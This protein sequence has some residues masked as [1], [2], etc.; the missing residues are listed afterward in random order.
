MSE[1]ETSFISLAIAAVRLGLPKSWLLNE[2]IADRVPHI[3]IGRRFLFNLVA[4]ERSL[5][6]RAATNNS[7]QKSG[8]DDE[9]GPSSVNQINHE[10]DTRH[11]Q[12][13]QPQISAA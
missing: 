1:R 13:N 8:P 12:A 2:A 10:N 4:V 7:A 5:M 3:K 9:S 6:E 11:S